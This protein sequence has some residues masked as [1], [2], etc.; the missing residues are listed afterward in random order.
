MSADPPRKIETPPSRRAF[1]K[2]TLAL[3]GA[4]LLPLN[5]FCFAKKE[6]QTDALLLEME[7]RACRYF[8]DHA[9]HYTGLVKDRATHSAVDTHTISSIAATGFGLSALCIADR[10]GFLRSGEAQSRVQTALE[11]IARRLPHERGFF[12]HFVDMNTGERAWKCELSS[13]DTAL[14]LLGVLHARAYFNSAIIRQLAADIYERVDWRWMMNGGDT[15]SHGWKPESGFLKS[16][17]DVY[18]EL[19]A[20]YLLAIG[21]P[22]HPIPASS[23]E[24]WKRPAFQYEE[25]KYIGSPAPIFVHQYSHAWVD[26][27]GRYDSHADYF[28]NS[29]IATLAH[30]RFCLSLQKDF[31]WYSEELWG[32]SSSDSEKGYVA[33]GGPPKMGDIDGTIVPCA[34]AGSLPFQPEMCTQVLRNIY[35]NYPSAWTPYGFV[36]AFHPKHKWYDPDVLGIDL[37]IS[38]LMA[39]NHRTGGVWSSFMQ[40]PEIGKAM[41]SVGFKAVGA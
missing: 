14:L 5:G 25:L 40:N 24:A 23:W 41:K 34:V 22:T 37:G 15:L 36:D 11:F 28:E 9:G 31:P 29:R 3:S 16:R 4:A 1:L 12:F 39:E 13:I 20:L 6:V 26:F 17:W 2:G 10:N 8:M 35:T 21:S 18:C 32:I 33:W 30:K 19:M 38:L 7:R 27:R